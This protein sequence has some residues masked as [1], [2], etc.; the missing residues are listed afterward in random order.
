M[1][2]SGVPTQ[3]SD[4]QLLRTRLHMLRHSVD[5]IDELLERYISSEQKLHESQERFQ[6]L[7][8]GVK[9]Y[10][11]FMLDTQGYVISWNTGAQRI[12]GYTADEIIGS[13]FSIF[14]PSADQDAGKPARELEIA[15][16]DG[17]YE[18]EGWRIRKDGSRFWANVLITA[19]YDSS[20]QLR[21][22]GKV[23]RDMT[24][25]KL[26]EEMRTQLQERNHQLELAKEARSQA[27][28]MLRSRDEFLTVTAHELRTP[29]TSL[30]GYAQLL[31]RR[32]DQP[33][34]E[35]DQRAI[36][37][38]I[39]QAQ[40]LNHFTTMLLD[41]MRLGTGHR[42]LHRTELDL[43][44]EVGHIVSRFQMLY[45]RHTLM[46]AA[47]PEPVIIIGD[48]HSLEQI[49]DNLIQNAIK[50]SPLGGTIAISIELAEAHARITIAD[51][52][53]G[54]PATSLPHIFDRFYRAANVTPEHISGMGIGLFIV[55]EL[56]TLH[57]GTIDVTSTP[58]QGT[59]FRVSLPLKP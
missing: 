47:P 35:R 14:Y 54:I 9:D 53:I 57:G 11:I 58:G 32:F 1:D 33:S 48:E 17:R 41:M 36:K 38:I 42:T 8:E 15:I 21:G 18:E 44:A 7:L 31:Q 30:L 26:A 22:F 59:S 5:E 51:Q 56:V 20:G 37:A 12:K 55:K 2:S 23:T 39:S 3:H 49:F 50:Y 27:E 4:I 13:H 43:R 24:E 52:G 25:R 46:L 6:L 10:A 19:L 16:Q 45:D 29:I 40:R 34:P 28:A